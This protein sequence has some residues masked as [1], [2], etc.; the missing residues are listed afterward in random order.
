M[1][2]QKE[3][4]FFKRARLWLLRAPWYALLLLFLLFCGI[5]TA[6]YVTIRAIINLVSPSDE[7]NDRDKKCSKDADCAQGEKCC[8]DGQCKTS[9]TGATKPPGGDTDSK[10]PWCLIFA[11]I[12]AFSLFLSGFGSSYVSSSVGKY[13]LLAVPFIVAGLLAL[14]SNILDLGCGIGVPALNCVTLFIG[15]FVVA[16]LLALVAKLRRMSTASIIVLT[17]GFL[18]VVTALAYA[19]GCFTLPGPCA[20]LGIILTTLG[21]YA[22]LLPAMYNNLR[23]SLGIGRLVAFAGVGISSIV[24]LAVVCAPGLNLPP[25]LPWVFAGLAGLGALV[26]GLYLFTD[27]FKPKPKPPRAEDDVE[28]EPQ[29]KETGTDKLNNAIDETFTQTTAITQTNQQIDKLKQKIPADE[30]EEVVTKLVHTNEVANAMAKGRNI[31][32]NLIQETNTRNKAPIFTQAVQ[33]QF[34]ILQVEKL[35]ARGNEKSIIDRLEK[36]WQDYVRSE[37]LGQRD[38]VF[39]KI[40]STMSELDTV[41]KTPPV[42]APRTTTVSEVTVQELPKTNESS[43]RNL[44][45]NGTIAHLGG[46]MASKS[47]LIKKPD[48]RLMIR[49]KNKAARLGVFSAMV[50]AAGLMYQGDIT[51]IQTG[52]NPGTI[53]TFASAQEMGVDGS[54]FWGNVIASR[55][56]FGNALF[57]SFNSKELSDFD[58]SE[59]SLKKLSFL[60]KE[61]K[62]IINDQGSTDINKAIDNLRQYASDQTAGLEG[63]RL[64]NELEGLQRWDGLTWTQKASETAGNFALNAANEIYN[65][66]GTYTDAV[67]TTAVALTSIANP[68]AAPGAYALYSQYQAGRLTYATVSDIMEGNFANAGQRVVTTAALKA[69][70]D[71]M[72][73]IAEALARTAFEQG[74]FYVQTENGGLIKGGSEAEVPTELTELKTVETEVPILGERAARSAPGSAPDIEPKEKTTAT[75]SESRRPSRTQ[76]FTGK[77]GGGSFGPRKLDRGSFGPRNFRTIPT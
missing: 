46:K 37:A 13:L 63:P 49:S 32:L 65:N 70:K 75:R 66:P 67:A 9:C 59:A 18:F 56:N 12:G 53:G 15:A 33:N 71:A 72:G 35:R 54:Q 2:R 31:A 61:F 22:M 69:A 20:L 44:K 51:G 52:I 7:E 29:E 68:A 23:N 21:S 42:Y 57:E 11:G 45:A 3:T 55:G 8:P 62:R 73:P 25:Y 10:V 24:A 76:R 39:K 41:L 58:G 6:I 27:I 74:N 64:L 47:T 60:D 4:G 16:A 28:E 34:A 17:T 1:E 77:L 40:E 19:T 50:S 43:L 48:G 26:L 30:L 36:Q 14:L 38:L 5:V